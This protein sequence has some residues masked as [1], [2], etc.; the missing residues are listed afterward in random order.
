MSVKRPNIISGRA[1]FARPLSSLSRVSKLVQ[2]HMAHETWDFDDVAHYHRTGNGWNGIG[3]NYWIAFDG[4]IYEGRGL[5]QG[6][7]VGGHNHYTLGIGY[8]GH[9]DRQRMTDAQVRAGA[10]LNAWLVNKY[11]LNTTDIIGHND[12]ASTACPGSNFRMDEL[13]QMTNDILR[14]KDVSVRMWNP[15]S[16]SLK[17]SAIAAMKEMTDREKYGNAAISQSWVEKAEKG[18][19]TMDDAAALGMYIA[20]HTK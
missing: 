15:T 10:Q 17:E 7:H 4:T 11:K 1:T 13:R 9:F 2:H 6:A 20:R 19:L 18:E 3:Y 14:G 8:Q 16:R 5:R 12:L